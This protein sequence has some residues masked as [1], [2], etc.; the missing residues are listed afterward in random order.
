MEEKNSLSRRSFFKLAL[1]G[2][3]IVPFMAKA[4]KSLAADACPAS[5][6][7]GKAVASPTE[8]M[9]KTLKY[10]T[11]AKTTKEAKF[12]AGSNCGNCKFYNAAKAEGGYAP[13]TMMGMKY[14]TNCGWCA[15]Y[16]VKA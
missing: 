3:A 5:A 6:P 7:A 16:A 12:K 15:S 9:G 8:G 11:D 14:V 2:A 4:T 10:V 13:C 1:A